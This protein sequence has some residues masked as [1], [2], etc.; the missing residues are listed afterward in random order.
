VS[1]MLSR[2]AIAIAAIPGNAAPIPIPPQVPATEGLAT[3]PGTRLWYWDTGGEGQAIVLM[4]PASVSSEIWLYQQP[5][6]AAA[7][8][9]V[10]AYSRRGY[11]RS[12]PVP[13][14][15]PGPRSA[16]LGNLLNFLNVERCHLVA[17]AAGCQVALDFA[18][19]H[20]ERLYSLTLSSGTGGVSDEDYAQT[21]ARIR[22][23]GFDEYPV[24]FRELSPAYRA[25][26]PEGTAR[27]K[28][29]AES[30]VTGR[31]DGQANLNR[32]DW[33][34]VEQ[35]PVPAL[36][37]GGEA[38]LYM[39]PPVMREFASHFP[40]GELLLVPEAGHSAYWEQPEIFNRAVLDFISRHRG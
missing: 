6:F 22:P 37:I 31:R 36:L 4:H 28:A 40:N 23:P 15:D 24:E 7:G 1:A 38:D 5:A 9:R 14:E 16:D 39:P 26:N 18:L 32:I 12:D 27:W 10:I 34:A 20:P 8:Y 19:S 35:M 21:L 2:S 13:E 29:I 33:A 17:S 25:S 11:F 3:L 30:A